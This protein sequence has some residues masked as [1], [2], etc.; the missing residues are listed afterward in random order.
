MHSFCETSNVI[1]YLKK[2]INHLFGFIMLSHYNGCNCRILF[3]K[4]SLTKPRSTFFSH[5]LCGCKFEKKNK[6]RLL[7]RDNQCG[8]YEKCLK[9]T[10]PKYVFGYTYIR[11]KP[12]VP[13]LVE[14]L[15]RMVPNR[16][17][18]LCLSRFRVINSYAN[19]Q[20]SIY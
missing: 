11:W 14:R 17:F 12:S 3:S 5:H 7:L 18:V 2:R 19:V 8:R 13:R 16:I 9:Y 1:S 6:N 10:F 4:N 15:G 20:W